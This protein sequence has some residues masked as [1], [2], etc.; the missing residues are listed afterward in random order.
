MKAHI[1]SKGFYSEKFVPC[2]NKADD[3]SEK[4]QKC[5]GLF[6]H[7]FD[8][9][10]SQQILMLMKYSLEISNPGKFQYF[11]T[12]RNLETTVKGWR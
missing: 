1:A 7:M 5:C 6:S 12:E 8:R 9:R 11:D 3:G 2:A 4:V 10:Y